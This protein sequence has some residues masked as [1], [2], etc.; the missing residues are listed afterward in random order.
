MRMDVPE[1]KRDDDGREEA[2]GDR[3]KD[4]RGDARPMGSEH[5]GM[6]ALAGP[7][8]WPIEDGNPDPAAP[9]FVFVA[10]AREDVPDLVA[11]VRRLR[12]VEAAE[13]AVIEAA[14]AWASYEPPDTVPLPDVMRELHAHA[15]RVREAVRALGDAGR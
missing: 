9:N 7:N 13:R 12:A 4:E 15:V 14:K 5:E 1:R 10:H 6:Y 2:G 11:E 3:G 8:G